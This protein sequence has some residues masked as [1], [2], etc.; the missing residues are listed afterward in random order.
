MITKLSV[1]AT[2]VGLALLMAGCAYTCSDLCAD[3]EDQGCQYSGCEATCE[4]YEE[5]AEAAECVDEWDEVMSCEGD[6]SDDACSQDDPC[7]AEMDTFT[8][9]IA[10]YCSHNP[11][12][13]VQP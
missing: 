5:L 3:A 10:P 6:N 7:Q 9:C 13:C 11:S 4:K 8:V 12:F 1:F 2:A